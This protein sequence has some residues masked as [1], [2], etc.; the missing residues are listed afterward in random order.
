MKQPKIL[1]VYANPMI[2]AIPVAPYGME[3]IAQSFQLAGC[4]VTMIAPF[5][6]ED[7]LS[8]LEGYLCED[9][10]L[11]GLSVRNIGDALVV[12]HEEGDAPFDLQF[13]LDDV[14]PLVVRCIELVGSEKVVLGGTA[15][16]SG[17][18][19][20]LRF[21]GASIALSGSV[22]DLCWRMVEDWCKKI[23]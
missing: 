16:S 21:L 7:P 17:P 18:L 13:F 10:S 11:I 14:R 9:W 15:L 3:R 20:V 1:L 8:F 4:D 2:S 23:N 12:R 5:I 6:E 22:D 19:P